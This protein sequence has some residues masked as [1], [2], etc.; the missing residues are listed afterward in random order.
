MPVVERVIQIE[1]E[2]QPKDV[3]ETRF[4]RD[5]EIRAADESEGILSGL[6]APFWK[7]EPVP[8][9]Y[10]EQFTPETFRKSV[11]EG[12]GRNAPLMQ[13]HDYQEFPIGKALEWEIREDGLHGTWQVDM[14]SDR[15]REV[16]R[17]ASQGFL[18]GLSVGF[19]PGPAADDSIDEKSQVPKVTRGPAK[20]REVSVVSVAAYPDAMITMHRSAGLGRVVDPRIAQIRKEMGFKE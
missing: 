13:Q 7:Y 4:Y 14:G 11:T 12:Q 5:V 15:A 2:N 1:C 3:K 17:L 19:Q 16:F 10:L 6:A 18:N 9:G 20:L 8:G